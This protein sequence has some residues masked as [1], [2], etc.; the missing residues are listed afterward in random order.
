MSE[1]IPSIIAKDF[2]EVKAKLEKLEGLIG[3]AELDVIDGAFAPNFSWSSPEDLKLVDGRIKIGAHLMVEYPE[4][5]IEDWEKVVDRI[6]IHEEATDAL[7]NLLEKYSNANFELGVAL[8]LET[9]LEKIIPFLDKIKY[10]Q[11]M[12]IANI[13]FQGQKFDEKVFDKISELRENF[14]DVRIGVDGGIGLNEARVLSD[15]GVDCL[16]VGSAIW[17]SEDLEEELKKFQS[18]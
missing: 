16:I 13:G 9:S 2:S 15:M 1:I 10:V 4:A 11:L 8:R 12:S 17:G 7:E 6:V 14:P 3:W 5:V 18:L